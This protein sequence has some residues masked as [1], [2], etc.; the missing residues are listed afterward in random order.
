[1]QLE[2]VLLEF[3]NTL[4]QIC[5]I[6]AKSGFCNVCPFHSHAFSCNILVKYYLG[7]ISDL[8]SITFVSKT[9][10]YF[11]RNYFRSVLCQNTRSNPSEH[12]RYRKLQSLIR[13]AK[14]V[15][16]EQRKARPRPVILPLAQRTDWAFCKEGKTDTLVAD[17]QGTVNSS[18]S[19][20]WNKITE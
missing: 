19:R 16:S 3:F 6:T 14:H 15:K 10:Q 8:P 20:N 1:M 5:F 4:Q 18:Y 9:T 13:I 12:C 11:R 2:K 17:L 7:R